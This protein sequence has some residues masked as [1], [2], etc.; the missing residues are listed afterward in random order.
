MTTITQEVPQKHVKHEPVSIL[1]RWTTSRYKGYVPEKIEAMLKEREESKRLIAVADHLNIDDATVDQLRAMMKQ[2]DTE[3]VVGIVDHVK[4]CEE[5]GDYIITFA[6]NSRFFAQ[7]DVPDSDD[8]I[9]F[10]TIKG[11]PD[12]RLVLASMLVGT[13][14]TNSPVDDHGGRLLQTPHLTCFY[15]QQA[16]LI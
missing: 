14:D 3:H 5:T 9:E 1:W 13:V 6:P 12:H 7:Y 4:P 11:H 8:P 2:I 10:V 15:F 16:E